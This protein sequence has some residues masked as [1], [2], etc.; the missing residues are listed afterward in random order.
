MRDAAGELADRLHLLRLPQRRLGTR[1]L[2]DLGAQ[3]GVGGGE[4][5]GAL[6]HPLLQPPGEVAQR[7]L[8]AP[9]L[10]D[11]A[12]IDRDPAA[13][14]GIHGGRHPAVEH[15]RDRFE[16]LR[17]AGRPGAD[18]GVLE[19]VAPGLGKDL[20]ERPAEQVRQAPVPELQGAGIDVGDAALRI[21]RVEGVRDALQDLVQARRRHGRF[22]RGGGD[23]LRHGCVYATSGDA[24]GRFRWKGRPAAERTQAQ[25]G[26]S[27]AR[28]LTNMP[29]SGAPL[30][31][32]HGAPSVSGPTSSPSANRP[33]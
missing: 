29:T 16:M 28:R 23:G 4:L 14:R 19:R 26:G 8:V 18:E 12:E 33:A 32:R 9:A 22:D 15:R 2:L 24:G 7:Q 13:G 5:G 31:E 30:D 20:H 6:G 27:A 21:E 17:G 10:V 25:P 3:P 1:P 11:V